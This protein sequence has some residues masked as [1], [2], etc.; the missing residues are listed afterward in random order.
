MTPE[1]VFEGQHFNLSCSSQTQIAPI[2]VRYRLYKDKKPLN[3]GQVFSILASKASSGSYYC[4]A[5]AKGI[6]KTSMPLVI[7]VK[8]KQTFSA[9]GINIEYRLN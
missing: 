2:D 1:L 4:T 3:D 9:Y 8:G 5:E 7:N 6:N